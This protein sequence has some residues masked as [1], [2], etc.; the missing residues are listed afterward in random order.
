MDTCQASIAIRNAT[1]DVG[2]KHMRRQADDR[3]DRIAG[4]QK[5]P[6]SSSLAAS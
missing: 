6:S 1:V 5:L 3:C 4:G 2:Q